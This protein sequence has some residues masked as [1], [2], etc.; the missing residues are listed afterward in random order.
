MKKLTREWVRKAEA[1]YRLA[2]KLAR[3]RESFHDQI[4]FHSQQ[5]AEKYLKALLQELG[6]SIPRTHILRDVLALLVP[7]QRELRSLQRGLKFLTR[8]T[9]GTRY[10]G[11]SA[12][13]R[14]A[15]A[16]V[17]WAGRVRAAARK[18]LRIPAAP[19]RRKKSP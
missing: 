4:C 7:Y 3:G 17:R 19:P 2:A 10:P 9:V 6:Y 18:L 1:D 11:E 15:D 5:A 14:Q 12:S 8:F 13:K 16:A